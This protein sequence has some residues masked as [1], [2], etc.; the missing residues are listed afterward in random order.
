[1]D[2]SVSV[3]RLQPTCNQFA[4]WIKRTQFFTLK[5]YLECNRCGCKVD[6]KGISV[7]PDFCPGC[8]SDMRFYD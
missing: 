5:P 6:P 8:G 7:Y 4:T 2:D 3:D 1:M